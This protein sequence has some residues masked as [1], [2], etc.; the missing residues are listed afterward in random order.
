MCGIFGYLG[1]RNP[2]KMGIEGLKKL[3]YRGYD[4]A[5]IAGV[6]H[7]KIIYCKEVGKVAVLEKEVEAAH[8]DLELSIA[9]TRWATHGKPSQVNAHPHFNEDKSLAVV[10]NGIIENYESIKNSLMSDGVKFV[11][12]TD[13]EVIAHLISKF[14]KGDFL[15]AVLHAIPLMKGS[16]AFTVIHKDF[17]DRIIAVGNDCPLIVGI[18]SDEA[19]IS[20]DA[21]AFSE[22]TQEVVYLTNAE[23]AVV[24]VNKLEVYGS[25][26][27]S[28][29]KTV[30]T[31]EGISCNATKGTFEH[32]TL[33]EIFEQ[34]Q[35]IRSALLSRASE[36]F[37]TAY[38][39][40][41][42]EQLP[43]LIDA[44]RILILGCGT[45]WHAGYMAS[46]LFE[47]MARIPVQVEISSEYRYKNPVVPHRTLVLA[48]SQSGETADT[49]A[50]VRELKAKGSKV[51][52]LCNVHGST[53]SR[54]ADGCIY[55]RAGPEIA[56]CSTKAFTSQVVI[57]SLLCLAMARM[58]NMNKK[59]GQAFVA[60]IENL[61]GQVQ[62][63]LET[64]PHI[65]AIA[66]KYASNEN[67]FFVGRRYMYPASLEGALKLKEITYINANGYPAG[68]LKHGSI[69]LINKECPTVALCANKMTYDKILSN[70]MEIKARSGPI[71]AI[72]EAGQKGIQGIT[73]DVIWIPETIDEL[74]GVT[75][76][77]AAQLFAYYVALARGTDIDKPRNLAKSVTVE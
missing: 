4:S 12:E 56:V 13:T 14:Y 11:S 23:V 24:F 42:N 38:F 36:E 61:P 60:A 70:L 10:H 73:D 33:K 74:A 65:K 52:A 5:G 29:D 35:T 2:V 1:K 7:G 27:Q 32:Y 43:S 67:F 6:S 64:A 55:L 53:L 37:G 18:G 58:R 77:V 44:E 41:I 48:I 51:I 8:L 3:E 71:I 66:E 76:V 15:A 30:E 75:S 21:N 26:R 16:F 57:L 72:V 9:Q 45:S 49:I 22:Y 34:P 20:S 31:L 40:E 19:F 50:A 47:D 69:S 39:E 68:E 25:S 46:Y 54:I 62:Q 28:I 63:I 17:P 59:D